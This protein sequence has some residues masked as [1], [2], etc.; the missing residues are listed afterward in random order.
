M[1]MIIG[2]MLMIMI[3]IAAATIVVIG[4]ATDHHR[5]LPNPLGLRNTQHR[6]WFTLSYFYLP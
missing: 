2:S 5:R 1:A 6:L 3:I 4:S